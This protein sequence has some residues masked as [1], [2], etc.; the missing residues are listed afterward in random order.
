[1]SQPESKQPGLA[2]SPNEGDGGRPRMLLFGVT[3][4]GDMLEKGNVWYLRLYECYFKQ[5]DAI[6]LLGRRQAPL[7]QGGTTL[8]SVGSGNTLLDLLLAPIHLY[9]EARRLKPDVYLTADQVFSWWT[10]LL[11]RLLLRARVVLMPVAVPEELYRD[12]GAT[13]SG[14]PVWCER[15]MLRLSY[16][17]AYRVLTA[18]AA[19]GYVSIFSSYALSRDKL[20]V[21]SS[22]GEA[23]PPPGFVAALECQPPH[24]PARL[25]EP[26]TLVYVGRLNQEKLVDDLLQVMHRLIQWRP[27]QSFRLRLIGDGPA[28]QQLELLAGELGVAAAVEFVGALN[29][30]EI[31]AQLLAADAFMSPLTGMSLREAA[32]AALPIIAYNR[33]WIVGMLHHDDNALLVA[34][35]DVDG[36]AKQVLRLADDAD[37]RRKLSRN[38]RALAN[39]LWTQQ[40]L[41]ESL[42]E[43]HALVR[44]AA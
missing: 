27:Q 9:C 41:N 13:M 10:G 6:Y 37:L 25:G 39:E 5:V 14:L 2:A 28:R 38:I 35:R 17:S 30:A 11:V 22:F 15:I 42:A 3:K 12:Y 19:G 8:I 44:E 21:V 43:L 26:M 20:L 16:A 24:D 4:L 7:N 36:M 33:D 31:P 23:L 34:S 32:L 40:G 18:H 1:M 29:N